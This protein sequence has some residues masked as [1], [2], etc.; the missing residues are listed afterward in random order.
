MRKTRVLNPMA[1]EQD[2]LL[3]INKSSSTKTDRDW[4]SSSLTARSQPNWRPGRKEIRWWH[5]SGQNYEL[6][7]RKGTTGQW[8]L[9]RGPNQ[10]WDQE[11]WHTG[12]T[13]G[14]QPR[15]DQKQLEKN[16]LEMNPWCLTRISLFATRKWGPG[17][18]PGGAN[19]S[20]GEQKQ[21]GS[22]NQKKTWPGAWTEATR[23]S[24]ARRNRR[25]HELLQRAVKID[26][27]HCG[28][29][30]ELARLTEHTTKPLA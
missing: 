8:L 12:R 6:H 5:F 7:E 16:N 10:S 22:H 20:P 24:I 17:P 2:R 23:K 3:P 18:T 28:L 30:R 25:S 4:H 26:T 11:N 21:A 1:Q 27:D 14:K 29:E 15:C 9:A 13:Q 19:R